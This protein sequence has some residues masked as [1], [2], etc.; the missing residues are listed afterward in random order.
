VGDGAKQIANL[1]SQVVMM[2]IDVM[3][4]CTVIVSVTSVDIMHV[5]KYSIVI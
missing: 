3:R 1:T 5:S 4:Y 2:S